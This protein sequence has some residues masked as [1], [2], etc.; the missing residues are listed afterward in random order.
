MLR[1]HQARL[2]YYISSVY[3]LVL[4]FMGLWPANPLPILAL[5]CHDP[6]HTHV[7]ARFRVFENLPLPPCLV[8]SRYCVTLSNRRHLVECRCYPFSRMLRKASVILIMTSTKQRLKSMYGTACERTECFAFFIWSEILMWPRDYQSGVNPSVT[9][10][11]H[12]LQI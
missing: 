8:F 6:L 4:V 5:V 11:L 12:N 1:K 10:Y 7:G 9:R 2:W 3:F